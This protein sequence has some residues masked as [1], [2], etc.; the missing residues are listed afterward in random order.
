[1]TLEYINDKT[2][3]LVELCK[4]GNSKAQSDIYHMYV[5]AMYNTAL[6]ILGDQAEA[7]DVI[8]ESFLDV[9]TKITSFRGD[10]SIGSW[11]KAIVVNKAIGK[12][13]SKKMVF[14]DIEYSKTDF[15]YINNEE[16]FEEQEELIEKIKNAIFQLPSGFRTVLSLYLFEGYDH[17]EIGE[18]LGISEVT[19]RSQFLRSKARLIEILKKT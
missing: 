5:K 11:I 7:E 12:I 10:A 9:F 17:H 18:I 2:Q 6:R 14:E 1:M 19:S 15:E 3:K 13:R 16:D 4:Q 8:Q